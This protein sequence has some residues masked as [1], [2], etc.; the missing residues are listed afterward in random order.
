MKSR[1]PAAPRAALP[2]AQ[3]ALEAY[4]QVARHPRIYA[5]QILALAAASWCVQLATSVI[6]YVATVQASRG[7]QAA[8]LQLTHIAAVVTVLVLGGT[9]LFIGCQRAIV[10]GETPAVRHVFRLRPAERGVLRAV[11][12]YWCIVHLVPT[13]VVNGGYVA[14]ELGLAFP[15]LGAPVSFAFYWGWVLA[16]APLAVLS[17]PIALFEGG[18]EPLAEG[19]RRLNGNTARLFAASV[20]AFAPLAMF[21]IALYALRAGLSDPAEAVSPVGWLVELLL[22]PILQGASSFA[23][24]LVM[25]ALVATAYVRLSPRLEAVYRVFE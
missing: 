18:A 16:T 13:V 23:V 10:L 19:R 20:I 25:S 3:M 9:A 12:I 5:G 15:R 24:I 4:W 7:I 2:A 14:D 17:L 11:C 21:Q 22:M 1:L 6:A 8:F